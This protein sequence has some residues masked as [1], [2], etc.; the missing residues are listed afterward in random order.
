MA[1][2]TQSFIDMMK[3]FGGDLGL[4]KVDVDKL[5]EAHRKNFDALTRSAQVATEGTRSL[6]SKQREII[7]AAFRDA[8]A[9]ARDFKPPG[10]AQDA[11]S[12]QTEFAK[13]VFD[14]AMQNTRDITELAKQS[15]SEATKI[16]Q[17]RLREG[18]EEIRAGF[19]RSRDTPE[20]K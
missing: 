16:I 9:M 15:T 6:A 1:Q 3:E 19:D 17:D 10:S 14:V 18:L 7:E 13:K 8:A 5:I 12:R 4:P 11:L 2:S 20:K